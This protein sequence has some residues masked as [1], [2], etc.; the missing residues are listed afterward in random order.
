MSLLRARCTLVVNSQ[1]TN[2][3]KETAGYTFG[4]PGGR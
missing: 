1:I 3:S 2:G 4:V